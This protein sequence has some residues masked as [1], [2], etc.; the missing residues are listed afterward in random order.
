MFDLEQAIAEWRR[1]MQSGGLKDAEQ[2]DELESHL[3]EDVGRQTRAGQDA[4]QAFEMAMGEI[5]RAGELKDEFARAEGSLL[6]H[7]KRMVF[8]LAG[9][10]NPQLEMNMNQYGPTIE[11]RWATYLKSATFVFPAVL[12]WFFSVIFLLPK[13]NEICQRAGMQVFHYPEAP[14]GFKILFETGQWVIFLTEHWLPVCAVIAVIFA[15]LEWRSRRWPQFRRAA[16]GTGVFALNAL[17]LLS[18]TSMVVSILIAANAMM[19]H[20]R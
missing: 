14:S 17:L 10:P 13:A 15:V 8:I 12:L 16:L 3:R 7:W 6:E 5:G 19:Q 11:P 20:A 9:I 4:A 1:Q 18:I 2:L